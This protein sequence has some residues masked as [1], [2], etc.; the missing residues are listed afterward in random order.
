MKHQSRKTKAFWTLVKVDL[1]VTN[2]SLNKLE[3]KII[4]EYENTTM[5]YVLVKEE[6]FYQ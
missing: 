5:S 2:T 4:N 1:Y 6:H 3:F